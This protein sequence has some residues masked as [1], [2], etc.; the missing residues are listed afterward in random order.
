M[1]RPHNLVEITIRCIQSRFLLRPSE[2]LNQL[3]LGVLGRALALYPGIRL[4]AF[5]ALSNHIHFILSSPDLLTLASFMNHV[6]SN[7]A[8]EAGRLHRW[9]D[10]FWARRYRM[11]SIE[12]NH[13]LYARLHYL[14]S[15]GCK[16]NLV[17]EP[18]NWPGVS[19]DRALAFGEH[20][21]G[22]WYDRARFYDK[23]RRGNQC[24]LQDFAIR[25]PVPLSPLPGFEEMPDEKAQ[26][27]F[28]EL[29]ENIK[30]ETWHRHV[31]QGTSPIGKK[32]VLAQNPHDAPR[33]TKRS[34]APM[35]HA[36]TR[37]R[38]LAYV[39]AY[40]H[41]VSLYRQAAAAF[42]RGVLNVTFPGD[43]FPP[44]PAY[45]KASSGASPP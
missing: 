16:E 7:I 21:E 12:D 40:K 33:H 35:C 4:Y 13:E 26:K 10:K 42:R 30:E 19:S 1:S 6:M 24:R 18:L 44:P 32:A 41:F 29:F 15:H 36:S 8:R 17:A 3:L 28:F 45:C 25:Y 23:E 27:Y 39:Q 37:K 5:K 34:P 31:D 20:L 9:R 38:R 22:V 11:I 2:E 14:F 43:C